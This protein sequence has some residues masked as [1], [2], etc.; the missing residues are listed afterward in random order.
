M[1]NVFFGFSFSPFSVRL[2]LNMLSNCFVRVLTEKNRTKKEKSKKN[3][4]DIIAQLQ[5]D[6]VVPF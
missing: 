6:V 5:I 1:K 4:K 3:N 2:D